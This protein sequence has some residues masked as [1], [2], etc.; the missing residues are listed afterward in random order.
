MKT[1]ANMNWQ[2]A[3]AKL[4]QIKSM[5]VAFISQCRKDQITMVAGY[6]TF[7]SLL[8]VVPLVSVTF[9]ILKAFP[10]FESFKLEIED[11]IYN[12]FVP[13]SSEQIQLY[14]NSFVNN[15]SKMTAIG[16]VVLIFVALSLISSIDKTL[17][18]IF[19]TKR[20]RP[21]VI[22]FAVY[23]MVLTLGPVFVG[24]SLGATSYI[25]S[26]AAMADSYTPGVSDL[27]IKFLP[28]ALSTLAFVLLFMIVPDTTV[29]FKAALGG[30]I[31]AAVLF[32]ASKRG[33]ALYITSFPSY[34]VIY[35]ALA[36]IP[37]LFVWV[38]VSWI[39][40]LIGAECTVFID[41]F[42]LL[43]HL[44]PGKNTALAELPEHQQPSQEN[45][46][47]PSANSTKR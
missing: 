20:T 45:S 36:A 2:V 46:Q 6:L 42:N 32:E 16:I 7:V 17:N 47:D 33:F 5:A 12:N 19:N 21:V 24:L 31:V 13:N 41:K 25:V 9:S 27:F 3:T 40:V 43:E 23:W 34:Q 30:A 1:N 35:G 15:T 37:I 10:V 22:S 38:Y 14:I 44:L 29:K 8:S 39:V 11:F 26:I 4:L 18:Q 28:F